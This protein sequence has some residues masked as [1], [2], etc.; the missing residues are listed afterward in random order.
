MTFKDLLK[1]YLREDSMDYSILSNINHDILD[2][3][4][5]ENDR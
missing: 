1:K 3:E 4:F 2:K 5:N